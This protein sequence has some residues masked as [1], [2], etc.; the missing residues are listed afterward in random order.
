MKSLSSAGVTLAILAAAAV[1]VVTTW[2]LMR[3]PQPV[4]VV[5]EQTPGQT[6]RAP[7]VEPRAAVSL[8][9]K[10]HPPTQIIRITPSNPRAAATPAVVRNSERP[11]EFR[12]AG[13]PEPSIQPAAVVYQEV[14]APVVQQANQIVFNDRLAAGKPQKETVTSEIDNALSFA[15]EAAE[16]YVKDGFTVR[17][18]FW[19]GDLAVKGTK[20]IVHQLFKGNEYWFWMGTDAKDAKI[21]VHI[22]DSEGNLAEVE[23]WAKPHFAVARVVPK[24]TRAYYLIVEVEKSDR[25]RTPWALAYGFR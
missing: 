3:Q 9:T 4:V 16:P 1:G 2:I 24:K 5:F 13:S 6:G 7:R 8:T 22:Y 21:S 14:N 25:E 12:P 15:L 23:A 17:E 10:E 11:A 18:D 19:G 20:A